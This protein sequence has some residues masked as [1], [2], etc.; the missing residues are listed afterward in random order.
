MNTGASNSA[1]VFHSILHSSSQVS[2]LINSKEPVKGT[3]V[4]STC[5]VNGLSFHLKTS[6]ITVCTLFMVFCYCSVHAGYWQLY[7][8]KNEA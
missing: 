1:R 3:V 2:Y 5:I 6:I 7:C 4:S 8:G